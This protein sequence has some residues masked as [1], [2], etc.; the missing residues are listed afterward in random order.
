MEPH[1]R[2]PLSWRI[3]TGIAGTVCLL[4]VLIALVGREPP[5][6][7]QGYGD[8]SPIL[9]T[10]PAL[11]LAFGMARKGGADAAYA[12]GGI[13]AGLILGFALRSFFGFF[14]GI[15]LGVPTALL[16]ARPH[17]IATFLSAVGFAGLVLAA[18]TLARVGDVSRFAVDSGARSIIFAILFALLGI[19]YLLHTIASTSP[20]PDVPERAPSGPSIVPFVIAIFALVLLAISWLFGGHFEPL[21]MI[22]LGALA[23]LPLLQAR[24]WPVGAATTLG[25]ALAGVTPVWTC[26]L[27]V[28]VNLAFVAGS[29]PA[30]VWAGSGY[31]TCSPTLLLFGI[32]W[33]IALAVVAIRAARLREPVALGV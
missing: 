29:G 15:G 17:R 10:I 8:P 14:L 33:V 2:I 25:L 28:P 16:S 27:A 22:A 20:T 5:P 18:A 26:Q 21:W 4:Y 3:A 7:I 1:L 24:A 12:A 6:V 32:A 9:L 11:A 23:A 13:I 30:L 31:V 19:A